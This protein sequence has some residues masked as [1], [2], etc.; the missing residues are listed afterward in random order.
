MRRA[1]LVAIALL[2]AC[3]EPQPELPIAGAVS[4]AAPVEYEAWWRDIEACSARPRPSGV[5]YYVVEGSRFVT[6]EGYEVLAAYQYTARRMIFAR[7]WLL[8]AGTV[9][10]EMLHAVLP[11]SSDIEHMHPSM[12]ACAELVDGWHD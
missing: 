12:P 8:D 1:G 6:P 3:T 4:I 9:R 5:T 2:V 11:P 7:R 10:H